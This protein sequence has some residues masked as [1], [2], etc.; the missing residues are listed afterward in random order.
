MASSCQL[1]EKLWQALPVWL[2]LWTMSTLGPMQIIPQISHFSFPLGSR[3]PPTPDIALLP[4]PLCEP[5]IF[6]PEV[7]SIRKSSAH[8]SPFISQARP[9]SSSLWVSILILPAEKNNRG[10]HS[11]LSQNTYGGKETITSKEITCKQHVQ[12]I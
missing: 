11:V 2:R 10:C 4:G 5:F 1:K 9:F 6:S 3:M 8:S 7:S 12:Y